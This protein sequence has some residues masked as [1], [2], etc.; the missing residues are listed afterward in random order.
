MSSDGHNLLCLKTDFDG[1]M[2]WCRACAARY[3]GVSPKSLANL[4]SAG[5]GPRNCGRHGSPRYMRADLD[6][7]MKEGSAA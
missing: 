7:W 1:K 4:Y 2:P 5:E 3:L 6:A